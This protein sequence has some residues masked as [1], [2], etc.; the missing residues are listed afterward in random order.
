MIEKRLYGLVL[1]SLII[2]SLLPSLTSSAQNSDLDQ[3]SSG[4]IIQIQGFGIY[5]DGDGQEHRTVSEVVTI[6][7]RSVA[8]LSVT[9][10]ETEPSAQVRQH[11]EFTRVFQVCNAGNTTESVDISKAEVPGPARL[12]GLYFDID[13]SGSRT[14]ADQNI[15]IGGSFSPGLP[16]GGCIGV[17][18]LVNS[19]T[20]PVRTNLPIRLTARSSTPDAANGIQEA[21][22]QIINTVGDGPRLASPDGT[23][24]VLLVNGL[25]QTVATPNQTLT[26]TVA[27]RN[28]GDSSAQGVNVAA[29]LPDELEYLPDS[30]KLEG[31]LLSTG[32]TNAVTV[33]GTRIGS[34][35][36]VS[37]VHVGFTL[38][39]LAPG[40]SVGIEFQARVKSNVASGRGL[41]TYVTING[42]NFAQVQTTDAL[43]VVDPF[44]I[45]FVGRGGRDTPISGAQVTLLSDP[46]NNTPLNTQTGAGFAPNDNNDNPDVAD[47]QGRYSFALQPDQLGSPSAPATYY[48]SVTAPGFMRRMLKVVVSPTH[49]GL[50]RADISALDG[51]AIAEAGG[52]G[53]VQNSVSLD[54]LAA[55]TVNVPM[56]EIS[57]LKID[58]TADKQRVEIGEVITYTLNIQ[59]PTSLTISNLIVRDLPPDS[60]HYAEG[61]VQLRKGDSGATETLSGTEHVEIANGRLILKFDEIAP[62]SHIQIRYR[63]RVGANARDGEQINQVLAEGRFPNGDLVQTDLARASVYVRAGLFS[64]RQ[65]ILGR[66]YEDVNRNNKFDKGDLPI[67]GARVYLMNGHYVLTDPAGLYNFPAVGDGSVVIALDPISVSSGLLLQDGGEVSGRSWA[68]LL[69]TPLGGGSVLHQD[70]ALVR[71]DRRSVKE[72]AAM[73][74]RVPIKNTRPASTSESS[75]AATVGASN[76][77]REPLNAGTYEIA[78]TERISPVK[79][80]EAVIVSPAPDAPVVASGSPVQVRVALGWK[81]LL[82][83][84]GQQASDQNIGESRFDPANQIATYTFAGLTFPPG[85]NQIRVTPLGPKGERGGAVEI[86]LMGRGPAH[87]IEILPER[88]ELVGGGRDS[89]LATIRVRDQW[90]N[91]ALDGLIAIE[92]TNVQVLPIEGLPQPTQAIPQSLATI[93]S[94]D[95]NRGNIE[96]PS[97]ANAEQVNELKTRMAVNLKNGEARVKLVAPGTVGNAHLKAGILNAV[98]E[99]DVRIL[100]QPRPSIL[101]GLAEASFG[102]VPEIGLRGETGNRRNRFAFFFRGTIKE[103][104]IFTLSYDSMRPLN[105]AAG[106]DRLFQLDPLERNYPIFGDSSTRFEEAQSNSKLYARLDRGRSYAMF[107]DFEAGM[108]ELVLTGYSRKLTGVKLHLEDK[109]GSFVTVTG[110]RPDTAFA[111]DVI[112]GGSLSLAQLSNAEILPG[113]ETVKLEVRDRR[114][115]EI[116]LSSETLIRSVDYNLDALTGQI[117]F[118]RFISMFDY[119]LNLVQLVVT[120]EHRATGLNSMALTGRALKKFPGLGLQIGLSAVNQRQDQFATFRLGGVDA[121]VQLTHRGHI[122]AAA[123]WSQGAVIGLVSGSTANQT[124]ESSGFAYDI[125]YRQPVIWHEGVLQGRLAGAS[126]GFLNP[127]G[128]T[129]TPGSRRA[130]VSFSAKPRASSVFKL[131]FL[132]ERNKTDS[133]DNTRS[134]FSFA[135]SESV[136]DNLKFNFGYDFRDFSDTKNARDVRSN[137]FT[138]GAEWAA[139]DKL[140]LTARREQNLGSSDPSYPDQTTL[141][142][143]YQLNDWAKLFYT[144][145]IASAPIIPIADTT[146]FAA[147][148]THS[149]MAFGVETK[150][151][152]FT[153]M[154][155]RYQ[156]DRGINTTDSFAVIGLVNRF[157]VTKQLSVELGYE[158]G[159]HVKG[160]GKS[161]NSITTGAVW[162]PKENLIGNFRYELRDR[163]GKEHLFVIG[164]AGRVNDS[165]T[166]LSRFQFTQTQFGEQQTVSLDGT[167]AAAIRPSTNDKFGLLLSYNRRTREIAVNIANTDPTRDR[168]ETL[169]TDAFYQLTPRFELSGRVAARF[170]ANGQDNT[171]FVSTLTYLTQGRAQYRFAKQFDLAMETRVLY[172]PSSFTMRKSYGAELGYWALP[173]LRLGA[174]YNFTSAI[175]PS[176]AVIGGKRR[177]F[178][179]NISTK[180]SNLFDLFGASRN[181]LTTSGPDG[182]AVVKEEPRK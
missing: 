75:K 78:A 105:R 176:G 154:T 129:V 43:A 110:A 175:E 87:S 3:T 55:L 27:L 141:G 86:K 76:E 50:F 121:E 179:F 33:S 70:F 45:V 157:P 158:R 139:T 103:K 29:I 49:S 16:P 143:T 151:S 38:G 170:N 111:R 181:D 65:V 159:F 117:F 146:G 178:Y 1:A 167:A 147:S 133:V 25:A 41:R 64:T 85:P 30:L 97:V 11:E 66:V 107:G 60:F 164:A 10:N 156:I 144:Q 57:T 93:P 39:S 59:N 174:G 120:Y 180:L 92:A 48:L 72:E 140:Q 31:K 132:N 148:S 89:M 54:D 182:S 14:S 13:D 98:T 90:G 2:A 122:K 125:D 123:A 17:L 168:I 134:T 6:V 102:N 128:A 44:G 7:V 34:D 37:T 67:A 109:S 118:L 5:E 163:S 153:S 162:Q 63:L 150:L 35:V 36:P 58:K 91:P 138:L 12:I 79:P 26:Y 96:R 113:S 152:R 169:S 42:Q 21:T 8:L 80:G 69:R 19:E 20:F 62:A 173:D 52:Y 28:S 135:W 100:A 47:A 77:L 81:V 127:F 83:V 104:N 160:Q 94:L 53:L 126:A 136:R 88:H 22:G 32:N 149:E 171:P 142:A 24:P 71:T 101:V 155:G 61:T 51:Q 108:N 131:G 56:F 9:P 18:I 15:S 119:S 130:E 73:E 137:L 165:I 23:T 112:P 161:F 95:R 114:N 172:Q 177:G 99:T 115:P 82:D 124:A 116:I 4:Q 46:A 166:A 74:T 106:Q 145:R 84:N 68:R 40:Q